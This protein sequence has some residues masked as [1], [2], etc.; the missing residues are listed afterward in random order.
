MY[1]NNDDKGKLAQLNYQSIGCIKLV[2]RYAQKFDS[3]RR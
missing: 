1:V 3:Q 2:G